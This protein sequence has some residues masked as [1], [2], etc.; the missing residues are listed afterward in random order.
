M[1]K[2]HNQTKAELPGD[3]MRQEATLWELP[4]AVLSDYL[5]V[6]HIHTHEMAKGTIVTQTKRMDSEEKN[7]GKA[8]KTMSE[9]LR[10][11]LS[12]CNTILCT[13]PNL[14]LLKHTQTFSLAENTIET[15]I[16]TL[17]THI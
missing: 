6:S 12:Q 14:I 13:P 15:S 5:C 11:N 8:H 7:E 3:R 10:V 16:A 2:E 9:P 17:L 1:A 4:Y